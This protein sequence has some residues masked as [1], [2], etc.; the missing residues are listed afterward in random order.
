MRLPKPK[1][2]HPPEV[3]AAVVAEHRGD[4]MMM[5]QRLEQLGWS[6]ADAAWAAMNWDVALLAAAI[7]H[8]REKREQPPTDPIPP[9][10][11]R[12]NRIRRSPPKNQ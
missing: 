5:A 4:P 9:K 10:P 8:E 6:P 11:R 12:T 3:Y 1:M 2:L 7:V